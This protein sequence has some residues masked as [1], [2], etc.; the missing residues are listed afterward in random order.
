MTLTK[1]QS[2]KLQIAIN[3]LLLKECGSNWQKD[4]SLNHKEFKMPVLANIFRDLKSG[5][6]LK[7]SHLANMMLKKIHEKSPLEIKNLLD[8][9]MRES[10]QVKAWEKAKKVL[11]SN[12]KTREMDQLLFMAA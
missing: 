9:F 8:I 1:I 6:I 12:Q 10:E 2:E 7:K 3:S 5:K 11:K 4:F